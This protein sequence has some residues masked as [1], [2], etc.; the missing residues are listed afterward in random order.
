MS[1]VDLADLSIASISAGY[2]A[3][4]FTPTEVTAAVLARI[5][6]TEPHLHAW[7]EVGQDQAL[8]AAAIAERELAAGS[9]RG[10]LHGVPI[11]VKDIFDVVGW[12]T[13][14]G[15]AAR[16]DAVPA[17]EDAWAVS[18]LREAGAIVLG[19]T[20]TQ[21]F[22]AGVL[23]APARNPWDPRRAPGG[24]S[25][26]SAAAVAAGACFAA[27]GSDTGGSIRIPAAACGVVGFK[28][29]FAQ[30]DLRGVFPLSWSLD[31]LGPIAR[32]V[33]DTETM[34]RALGTPSPTGASTP[35]TGFSG[36]L[37][38]L[39]IGVSRPFFFDFLQPDVAAAVD[40]AIDK[41]RDLGAAIVEAPWDAGYAARACGFII[42]RIETA[43]VHD[44][45]ATHDPERFQRYGPE[46]RLRVAAGRELPVS[47]YTNALRARVLIRDA[48]ATLFAAHNLDAL[49]A[50][51]L[52][53]TA[54]LA[55]NPVIESTGRDESVG[56]GWTRLT[57]PFNATG[58]PVLA[59][60]C[61]LDRQ[62]LPVGMQ[63]AGRPGD[64]TALFRIGRAYEVARG[65][66]RPP[67]LR[68]LAVQT[69]APDS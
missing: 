57:M 25:G 45:V 24:S 39:R 56:A 15:S 46:L 50:P 10:L 49:V 63:I 18:K 14:C 41:L 3:G 34:Y 5:A 59:V 62:G 48:M 37:R 61:G 9:D 36:S 13:R 11:G 1:A 67:L 30:F 64:E 47:L 55:E 2:R 33:D 60:P 27:L 6:A 53:T 44:R 23:S 54:V 16:E 68:E 12:P 19:K 4:E 17:T 32:S 22:A 43:A 58:Q 69:E 51:A 21:E 66:M 7:V 26:G 20:V 35:G 40:V 31:T 29:A 8:A 42:N 65:P 52:P 38:G 28:P